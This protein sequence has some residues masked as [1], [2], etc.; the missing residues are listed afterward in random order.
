MQHELYI[1]A[2]QLLSKEMNPTS[3]YGFNISQEMQ[4]TIYV[5]FLLWYFKDSTN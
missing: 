1:L 2:F 3:F 5:I 4:T